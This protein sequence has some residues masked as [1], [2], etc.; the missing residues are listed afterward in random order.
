M[1]WKYLNVLDNISELR[2]F[3]IQHK[4]YLIHTEAKNSEGTKTLNLLRKMSSD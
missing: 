3:L 1:K 2:K 4:L